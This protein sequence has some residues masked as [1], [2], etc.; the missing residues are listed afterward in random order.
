MMATSGASATYNTSDQLGALSERLSFIGLDK[1]ALDL[2]RSNKPMIDVE[3]DAALTKFYKIIS[4]TSA[5]QSFFSDPKM[6]DRA[7]AAQIRHWQAFTSGKLD[8]TYIANVRRVGYTHARIGLEP[9]WYIGGYAL[10]VEFLVKAIVK[11]KQP[12]G[13]LSAINTTDFANLGD[14]L[15]A[16]VKAVFLDMDYSISVYIEAAE[17]G[18]RVQEI[19]R[20][21]AEEDAAAERARTADLQAKIAADAA[22]QQEE[23]RLVVDALSGGLQQ[24]AAKNLSHRLIANFPEAYLQLQIDFNE[25]A[26]QIRT[27]MQAVH[28]SADTIATGAKEITSASDDLARRTE[29]QAASLEQTSAALV[30]ITER[31]NL[32]ATNA[33][34]AS[35]V[36]GT[37]R[38]VAAKSQ[39]IVLQTSTAISNIEKSSIEIGQIIGVIDEIAFQTNLLALNAGVEAARAGD[40]G[41]G[42][43]VVASEVRALAQRSASAAKDIKSLI[44]TSSGQVAEGVRLVG[45]TTKS[46]GQI[47]LQS[48]ETSNVVSKIVLANKDQAT[49]LNELSVA[50]RDLDQITQQNAAMVEQAT[51]ASHSLMHETQRLEEMVSKFQLGNSTGSIRSQ[52]E[53]VVPHVFRNTAPQSKGTAAPANNHSKS[54]IAS[55]VG[56]RTKQGGDEGWEEF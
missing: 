6:A 30:Q 43:A 14:T 15:V 26:E 40:A 34:T 10:L 1:N 38:D 2:L 49:S 35:T 55:V 9:R 13:M 28:S 48:A 16:L 52:L 31:V 17:E 23:L 36:A 42:F 21:K 45:E 47:V 46:L 25:A 20:R 33:S 44:S 56:S 51:A 12:S 39:Q 19:E 18:K 3:L 41:R 5:I 11:S 7:K 37:A 8:E 27:A 29:Q 53:K 22:I 32:T 24:L 4:T 54:K 50:T